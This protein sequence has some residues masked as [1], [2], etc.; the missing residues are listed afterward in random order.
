MEKDTNIE[1]RSE[2]LRNVIGQVPPLLTP[3]RDN[4]VSYTI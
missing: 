1:L 2:T 3:V 4:R